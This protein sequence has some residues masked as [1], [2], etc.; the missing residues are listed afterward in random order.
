MEDG[1]AFHVADGVVPHHALR[2]RDEGDAN[3]TAG[4]AGRG[5][6]HVAVLNDSSVISFS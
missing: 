3:I 4:I 1:Y 6:L 2:L 5:A